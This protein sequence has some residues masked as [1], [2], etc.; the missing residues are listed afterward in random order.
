MDTKGKAALGARPEAA[1]EERLT[2]D[3]GYQQRIQGLLHH[4]D[5]RDAVPEVAP[6]F[7]TMRRFTVWAVACGYAPPDRLTELVTREIEQQAA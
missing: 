5:Q 3:T 7:M 6:Q 4:L 2:Q 1:S